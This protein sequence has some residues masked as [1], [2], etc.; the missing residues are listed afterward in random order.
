MLSI[1]ARTNSRLI[2]PGSSLGLSS[3]KKHAIHRMGIVSIQSRQGSIPVNTRCL[4]T[5]VAPDFNCPL[6]QTCVR[7]YACYAF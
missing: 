1:H 3:A 2:N 5:S 6:S 4:D 7:S